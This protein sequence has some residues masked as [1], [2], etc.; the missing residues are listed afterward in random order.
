MQCP[1]GVGIARTLIHR[2][3]VCSRRGA[4]GAPQGLVTQSHEEAPAAVCGVCRVPR[5]ASGA[6]CCRVCVLRLFGDPVAWE[7]RLLRVFDG[8]VA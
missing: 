5:V 2:G 6:V 8:P 1:S 3:D 4:L 7:L